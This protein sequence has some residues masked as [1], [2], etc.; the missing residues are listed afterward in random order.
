MLTRRTLYLQMRNDILLDLFFSLPPDI[1]TEDADQHA[2]VDADGEEQ[3]EGNE[4]DHGDGV[5]S[6]CYYC[7]FIGHIVVADVEERRKGA[8]EGRELP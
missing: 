6:A 1:G 7:G 3:D 5:G 2:R 8:P 4:E